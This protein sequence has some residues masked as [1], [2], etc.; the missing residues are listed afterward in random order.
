M[1]WKARHIRFTDEEMKRFAEAAAASSCRSA[2]RLF[3]V[4]RRTIERAMR[5]YRVEQR[6]VGNFTMKESKSLK[7][8]KAPE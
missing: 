2:A 3:Q 5:M 7:D 4:S 6:R 8:W 1:S